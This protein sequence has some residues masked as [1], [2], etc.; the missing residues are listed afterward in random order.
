MVTESDGATVLSS[1][2]ALE[3]QIVGALQSLDAQHANI[4]SLPLPG[5]I[6]L[7]K[8]DLT[9]MSDDTTAFENALLAKAPVSAFVYVSRIQ[10]LKRAV[11]AGGHTSSSLERGI[12]HQWRL[13]D[14]PCYLFCLIIWRRSTKAH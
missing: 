10:R 14:C 7:V 4:A 13:S 6:A 5:T 11:S 12:C 3:P 2:Q 8:S 1:I 9:T